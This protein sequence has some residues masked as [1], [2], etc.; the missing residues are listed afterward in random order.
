[1]SQKY[2]IRLTRPICENIMTK[3]HPSDNDYELKKKKKRKK[4]EKK[5]TQFET[6]HEDN[7]DDAPEVMNYVAFFG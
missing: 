4:K 6:T 7:L 5:K 3:A 2:Q 1:M